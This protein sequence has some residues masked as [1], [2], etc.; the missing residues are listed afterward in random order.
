MKSTKAALMARAL[1]AERLTDETDMRSGSAIDDRVRNYSEEEFIKFCKQ[2]VALKSLIIEGG[3]T[4]G[5]S[6]EEVSTLPYNGEVRE[7]FDGDKMDRDILRSIR[8]GT[9]EDEEL[10]GPQQT[11]LTRLR[12][13]FTRVNV[14]DYL[15]SF[16]GNETGIQWSKIRDAI[17]VVEALD[18]KTEPLTPAIVEEISRILKGHIA[19]AGTPSAAEFYNAASPLPDRTVLNAD[20]KDLGLLTFDGN[21]ATM[22]AV[23][24]NPADLTRAS[25][26]ASDR[27]IEHKREALYRFTS[28]YQEV[29]IPEAIAQAQK[30]GR[31]DLLERINHVIDHE[32]E[33]L[34]LLGGDE[35]TISLHPVFNEFEGLVPA[36]VE[37][38]TNPAI[39]NARVAVTHTGESNGIEGHTTAMAASEAGHDMIKKY[40]ALARDLRQKAKRD[41]AVREQANAIAAMLDHVYVSNDT[42]NDQT[43]FHDR[44]GK[45][46]DMKEI[47]DE[48]DGLLGL[49]GTN[50]GN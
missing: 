33:P 25:M 47:K 11:T 32:P 27:V 16:K 46:V 50:N 40:E 36:A 35:I 23:A 37:M 10:S 41:P 18:N 2:T 24:S 22:D 34:V 9:Y 31:D 1:A 13:Y 14:F 21:A 43:I 26:R 44:A 38:L 42:G 5:G 8:K 49:K 19:Q 15:K 45:K 39:A 12:N 30:L 20:I 29:L 17:P 4:E 48:A 7:V 6:T 3:S 28:F